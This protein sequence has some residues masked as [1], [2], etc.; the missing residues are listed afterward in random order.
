MATYGNMHLQAQLA[1]RSDRSYQDTDHKWTYV[2]MCSCLSSC[3]PRF[4]RVVCHSSL[5]PSFL[6]RCSHFCSSIMHW[7]LPQKQVQS[8]KVFCYHFVNQLSWIDAAVASS[9]QSFNYG[10]K[11][12]ALKTKGRPRTN[13][14]LCKEKTYVAQVVVLGRKVDVCFPVCMKEMGKSRQ[15][16]AILKDASSEAL[17]LF[18]GQ[19]VSLVFKDVV[20]ATGKQQEPME[21]R[22]KD[23]LCMAPE[24]LQWLGPNPSFLLLL[25]TNEGRAGF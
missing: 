25:Q 22:A 5:L 23:V 7:L 2:Y 20:K 18:H 3:G 21:P 17:P 1:C 10:H 15:Q 9:A 6:P 11:V 12:L 4:C 19:P 16:L 14:R 24:K 8:P 13:P